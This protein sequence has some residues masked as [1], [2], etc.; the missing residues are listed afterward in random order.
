M[1]AHGGKVNKGNCKRGLDK[2]REFRDFMQALSPACTVVRCL[3]GMQR[4]RRREYLHDRECRRR[5]CLANES[6]DI[7]LRSVAS[8]SQVSRQRLAYP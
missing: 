5:H 8:A 6:Y 4:A 1:A 7:A 3:A 2:G